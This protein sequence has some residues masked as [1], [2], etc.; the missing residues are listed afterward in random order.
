MTIK[1]SADKMAS[2]DGKSQMELDKILASIIASQIVYTSMMVVKSEIIAMIR[3]IK[4]EGPKKK[5]D[6]SLVGIPIT[7]GKILWPKNSESVVITK[8]IKNPTPIKAKSLM[9]IGHTCP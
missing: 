5:R 1:S 4:T 7:C 9:R 2:G 6:V 3:G 8:T